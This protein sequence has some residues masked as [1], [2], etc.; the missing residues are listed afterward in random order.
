MA[1]FFFIKLA[2]HT[3]HL[4]TA[5]TFTDL[6]GASFQH[7]VTPQPTPW[8]PRKPVVT[9]IC[10]RPQSHCTWLAKGPCV[11][12]VSVPFGC[13]ETTMNHQNSRVEPSRA[14]LLM[15]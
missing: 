10:C 13:C 8:P 14:I 6:H 3:L 4:H 12:A 7:A 9:P 1:S 5:V 15:I 11:A 2:L